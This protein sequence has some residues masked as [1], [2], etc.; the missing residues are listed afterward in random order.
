M[1]AHKAGKVRVAAA[2]GSDFFGPGVLESSLGER[3]L[4]PL[5]AGKKV[6][7]WGRLDM[8][9]TYTY[10][11]DFGKAMAMIGQRDE[12]LGQA[13]HVPNAPTLTQ[14]DLFNIF[15]AEAGMPPKLGTITP[16]MMRLAGLFMPGARETVEMMYEFMQPFVVDSSKFV[17][18]FGDIA[19][20]HREAARKTLDWYKANSHHA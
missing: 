2:R 4:T 17:R 8:P 1:S 3:E 6:S 7:A 15:F 13:W 20:P 5:L 11:E 12:A 9:H 19:T 10:I 18:A 16:L 14:R